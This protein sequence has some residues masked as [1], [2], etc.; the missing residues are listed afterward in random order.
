[1][2]PRV[3][4]LTCVDYG[5]IANNCNNSLTFVVTRWISGTRIVSTS[6]A[7]AV[8]WYRCGQAGGFHRASVSAL[9]REERLAVSLANDSEVACL[10]DT[11][12]MSRKAVTLLHIRSITYTDR[13]IINSSMSDYAAIL[14]RAVRVWGPTAPAAY[15]RE[16]LITRYPIVVFALPYQP[17]NSAYG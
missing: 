6:E 14:V 5:F 11:G 12:K 1:M 15:I 8:L 16:E 10:C 3:G 9:T 2:T 4:R 17:R 7:T 13:R